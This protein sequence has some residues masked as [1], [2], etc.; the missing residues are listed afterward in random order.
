MFE[1]RTGNEIP[2][3]YKTCSLALGPIQPLVKWM[4]VF[5]PLEQKLRMSGTV[6]LFPRMNLDG[7]ERE[8]FV[9]KLSLDILLF[10][11]LDFSLT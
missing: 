8:E 1:Y 4:P 9:S 6:R 7:V 3:L 5:L 11:S 2:L 10:L